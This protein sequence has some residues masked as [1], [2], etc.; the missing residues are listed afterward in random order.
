MLLTHTAVKNAK[1]QAKTYRL[2]DGSG[3]FLQIDPKGGKY[4]RLR[5]F[6]TGKEKML[7]LGTYPE[8]SLLDAR[9]KSLAARK[10]VLHQQ[11]NDGYRRLS[12]ILAS[13]VVNCQEILALSL[14]RCVVHAIISRSKVWRSGMRRFRHCLDR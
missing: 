7:A 5:Y 13:A 6:H 9:D 2:K 12:L 11:T 8:V 3:L 10:L 14:F 4:W 1:P